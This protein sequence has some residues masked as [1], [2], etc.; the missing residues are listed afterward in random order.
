MFFAIRIS[1]KTGI[2]IIFLNHKSEPLIHLSMLEL[3]IGL[4]L[5]HIKS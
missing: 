5:D 2:G 4:E 3:V 1:N